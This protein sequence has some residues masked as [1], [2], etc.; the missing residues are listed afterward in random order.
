MTNRTW[1]PTRCLQTAPALPLPPVISRARSISSRRMK[2]SDT[3]YTL[4]T[5]LG[6]ARL[7]SPGGRRPSQRSGPGAFWSP[8]PGWHF[9]YPPSTR[10]PDS[11]PWFP[12]ASHTPAAEYVCA[13]RPALS[14]EEEPGSAA[15]TTGTEVLLE[16]C[17]LN[18]YI[19][20]WQESTR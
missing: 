4:R 9:P 19:F 11:Q 14:S 12:D 20:F 15:S 1:P 8:C 2:E 3:R 17:L 18:K 6:T 13:P 16:K 10:K 7:A 5:E